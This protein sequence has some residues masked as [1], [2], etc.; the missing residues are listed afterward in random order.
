[1]AVKRAH[2]CNQTKVIGSKT[3]HIFEYASLKQEQQ[4]NR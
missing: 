3:I 2:Q 4:D 1:M